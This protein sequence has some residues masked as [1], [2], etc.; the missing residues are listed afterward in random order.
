MKNNTERFPD[1]YKALTEAFEAGYDS[2]MNMAFSSLQEAPDYN[3]NRHVIPILDDLI[4]RVT[5][6]HKGEPVG[7]HQ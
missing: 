3:P 6:Q 4:E 5:N 7:Y 2:G 1:L